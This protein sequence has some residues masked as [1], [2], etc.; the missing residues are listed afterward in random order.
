[1]EEN[2]YMKTQTLISNQ[3][4]SHFQEHPRPRLEFPE[5]K[6]QTT[7]SRIKSSH[8]RRGLSPSPTHCTRR[9]YS[10]IRSMRVCRA[11]RK[12]HAAHISLFIEAFKKRHFQFLLNAFLPTSLFLS[13][14]GIII[15]LRGD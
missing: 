7:V 13:L 15:K 4:R 2:P 11:E 3:V 5:E 8:R 14:S 10:V 6:R 1:M 12:L 9:Q